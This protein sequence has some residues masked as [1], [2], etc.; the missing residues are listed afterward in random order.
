[1]PQSTREQKISQ[2][3]EDWPQQ[4]AAE[5]EEALSQTQIQLRKIKAKYLDE[6]KSL[7]ALDIHKRPHEPVQEAELTMG[8]RP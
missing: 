7:E 4:I 1:M 2:R 3:L 5:Q 6:R 8:M